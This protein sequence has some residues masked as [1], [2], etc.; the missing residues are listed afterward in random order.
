M[1]EIIKYVLFIVLTLIWGIICYAH[2]KLK[3]LKEKE[4][5]EKHEV[6]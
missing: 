3:K 5:R 1:S 6:Q 4:L 2:L